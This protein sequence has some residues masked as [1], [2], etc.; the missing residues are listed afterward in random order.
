MMYNAERF[1]HRL[2]VLQ[3]V[4]VESH[5]TALALQGHRRNITLMQAYCMSSCALLRC[6]SMTI[7]A[8]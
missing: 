6:Q 5:E 2:L 7:P 3:R 1:L 4:V 8:L